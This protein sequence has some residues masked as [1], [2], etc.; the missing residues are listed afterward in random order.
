MPRPTREGKEAAAVGAAL[1]QALLS[2]DPAVHQHGYGPLYTL[3]Q[4]LHA[5]RGAGNAIDPAFHGPLC[6]YA[7][8]TPYREN[9]YLI[10]RGHLKTTILTVAGIILRILRNPQIR[11]LIV[12]NKAENANAMLANVK[13]GL[14]HKWLVAAFPDV[15][16]VDPERE[17]RK[18]TESVIMVKRPRHTREGTVE[19][20]G[21]TG[22]LTSRHYEH[23]VYD[24]LVGSENSQTREELLKSIEFIKKVQPLLDPGGTQDFVG[25]TWH[26][27]DAYAWLLEQKTHHGREIGVYREECWED[28]PETHP[29]A[30]FAPGFGWKR[31]KFA[32]RFTVAAAVPGKESLLGIRAKMGS[33]WFAGQYLLNPSSPDTAYFDP[34]K[35]VRERRADMPPLDTM[36]VCITVDPALSTKAWADYSALAGVAFGPDGQPHIWDLRRGKWKEDELIA[37]VYDCYD[38]LTAKGAQV[39]A[40]GFEAIAFAKIFRRLF[41]I[42]GER[43][44]YYLPIVQLERDTK[45]TKNVRIRALQPVWEA[46]ELHIATECEA[47]EDFQEEARHFRTDRENTHD[48]MLDAVV[49][50]LQLRARPLAAGPLPSLYD[51]PEV[52]ER[53]AFE[54]A[55]IASRAAAGRRALDQT[56]L[57]VAWGHRQRV[58]QLEA[59]AERGGATALAEWAS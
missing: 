35:L 32:T 49:D 57:R 30:E 36:W 48:D 40:V 1:R 26:Y 23:I 17:A 24:D 50:A 29:Q 31:A 51:D 7:H 12:S 42:E 45:I 6:W 21:A 37:R 10:A 2:D 44:G 11:I 33:A 55:L 47:L 13:V 34:D 54:R 58:A 22:E 41:E 25:T 39:V 56:E 27:A 38:A 3:L 28:V 59:E 14:T 15:L 5:N 16:Y 4:L 18:W 43:R 52:T 46:G 53:V 8:T 19:S 20:I 9:L